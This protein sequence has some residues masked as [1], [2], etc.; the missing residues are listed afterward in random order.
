MQG[1]VR[2]TKKDFSLSLADA[3]QDIFMKKSIL[4]HLEN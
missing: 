1:L 3:G 4:G 2:I